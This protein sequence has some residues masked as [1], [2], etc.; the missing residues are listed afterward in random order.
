MNDEFSAASCKKS[1]FQNADVCALCEQEE[2]LLQPALLPPDCRQL[3]QPALPPP[4]QPGS[5]A[6]RQDTVWSQAGIFISHRWAAVN[7]SKYIPV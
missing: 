5:S 4:R 1:L 6:A 3:L 7:T 2:E